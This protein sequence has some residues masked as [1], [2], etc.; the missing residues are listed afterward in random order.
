M[1]VLA[2]RP[3][4]TGGEKG[5]VEGEI[6]DPV[7]VEVEAFPLRMP[8]RVSSDQENLESDDCVL[9]VRFD[10]L[11]M[12]LCASERFRVI[13]CASVGLPGLWKRIDTPLRTFVQCTIN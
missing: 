1:K 7:V 8:A 11:Q 6:A 3:I 2:D 9:P 10:H 5:E 12:A 13:P 4:L